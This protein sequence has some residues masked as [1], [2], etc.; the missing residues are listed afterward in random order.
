MIITIDGPSGTGKST[1][2]KKMAEAL[3]FIYIDTGAMFRSFAFG[4]LKHRI[5]F[6][7]IASIIKFIQTAPFHIEGDALHKRFILEGVD[8]TGEIRTQEVA[9]AASK[10]STIPE[11]R[12]ALKEQQR[13]YGHSHDAIFCGRDMGSII[14][15]RA[16]LKLY[17]TASSRIRAERRYHEISGQDPSFASQVEIDIIQKEID[18][19]DER[20]QNRAIAPLRPADDAHIIDTSEMSIEQVLQA[21]LGLW[22]T[23]LH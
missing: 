5:D 10:I 3:G 15:P 1:I 16:D 2:A 13:S 6:R 23:T 9:S 21:A 17:L 18:E 12:E 11:V 14:F 4:I 8:V 20:D 22:R 19:R 7:D